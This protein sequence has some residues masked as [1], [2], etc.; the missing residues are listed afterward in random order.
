MGRLAAFLALGATG[1][2]EG[3]P[4]AQAPQLGFQERDIVCRLLLEKIQDFLDLPPR[5][6][7]QALFE[8]DHLGVDGAPV[9]D[10]VGIAG[11][12]VL[13]LHQPIEVDDPLHEVER[14]HPGPMIM[15]GLS[16]LPLGRTGGMLSEVDVLHA[17]SRAVI[18]VV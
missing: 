11:I 3:E 6:A 14:L 2:P 1:L 16:S 4:A 18:S 15:A 12:P 8:A 7:E 13:T 10:V 9:L 5:L 17:Y